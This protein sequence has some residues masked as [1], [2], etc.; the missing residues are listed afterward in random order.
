MPC[1]CFLFALLAQ[2]TRLEQA[3]RC[4]PN[5]FL[6]LSTYRVSPACRADDDGDDDEDDDDDDDDDEDDCR[7]TCLAD[8]RSNANH[9][10]AVSSRTS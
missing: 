4:T 6:S 9:Q 10:A 2:T 8:D 7:S 3:S 5:S 1:M